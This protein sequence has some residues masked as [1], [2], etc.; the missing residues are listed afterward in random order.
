MMGNGFLLK[1]ASQSEKKIFYVKYE[2]QADLI[3]KFVDYSSKA[4][5]LKNQ[6]KHLLF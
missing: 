5:W 3:I 2:S 1:H 4:K 6:K